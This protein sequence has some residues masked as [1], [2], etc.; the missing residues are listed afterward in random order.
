MKFEFSRQIFGKSS[1]IKSVQWEQSCSMRTDG[2][3]ETISFFSQFCE[4]AK[5]NVYEM[6]VPP[7]CRE[8]EGGC[9]YLSPTFNFGAR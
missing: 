2:H 9:Q 3:G 1:N 8:G 5:K 6:A 4:R 7:V